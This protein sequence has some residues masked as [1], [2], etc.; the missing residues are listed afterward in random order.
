MKW[1][2]VR[3]MPTFNVKATVNGSTPLLREVEAENQ[4]RA[5]EKGKE[6]VA[7]DASA[8][9]QENISEKYVN[10]ISVTEI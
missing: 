9:L 6:I 1:S 8:E 2:E 7:R 5:V 4:R 3:T 10:V